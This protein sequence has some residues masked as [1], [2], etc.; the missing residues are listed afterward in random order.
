MIR[1]NVFLNR[2]IPACN[3]LPHEVRPAGTVNTFK[4]GVDKLTSFGFWSLIE[5]YLLFTTLFLI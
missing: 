3:N 4:N 2:L 5:N 1:E